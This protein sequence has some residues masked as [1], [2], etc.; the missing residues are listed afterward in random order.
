MLLVDLRKIPGQK[1]VYPVGV[2][3]VKVYLGGVYP[4]KAHPAKVVLKK[5]TLVMRIYHFRLNVVNLNIE[6]ETLIGQEK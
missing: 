4:V 1:R 3:P 5:L 6:R 2:Y